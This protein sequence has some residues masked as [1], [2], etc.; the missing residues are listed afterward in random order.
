MRVLL[1]THIFLW[2]LAGDRK[3]GRRVRT[4]LED[5]STIVLVSAASAWEIATKVRIG[6]LPD[7]E[8]VAGDISAAIVGQGFEELPISVVHAQR[9]GSLPGDHR[10]PF[11]RMLAAQAQIEGVPILSVDTAFDALGVPRIH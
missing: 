5:E 1:D 8:V 6:K 2:W 7:A 9:A 11:D 10:D 3:L 4:I